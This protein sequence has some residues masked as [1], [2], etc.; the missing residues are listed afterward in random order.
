MCVVSEATTYPCQNLPKLGENPM[1]LFCVVATLT[2]N[3][4]SFIKK[5]RKIYKFFSMSN[6]LH[7]NSYDSYFAF[8][9]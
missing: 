1:G 8:F 3:M 6:N 5:N 2:Y 9:L 4:S 7:L